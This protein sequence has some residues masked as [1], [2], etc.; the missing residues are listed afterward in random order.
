MNTLDLCRVLGRNLL[1]HLDRFQSNCFNALNY[2][3]R[4]L[5]YYS[6]FGHPSRTEDFTV[7]V[8]DVSPSSKLTIANS[9]F[10]SIS[11]LRNV[12]KT[13]QAKRMVDVP[14]GMRN[15]ISKI[16]GNV[17]IRNVRWTMNREKMSCFHKAAFF[18]SKQEQNNIRI[19][20][21][22]AKSKGWLRMQSNSG[23]EIW[24]EGKDI[25]EWRLKI[26]A[27]PSHRQGLDF[28]SHVPRFDARFEKKVYV[29]P[30]SGQIGN[31]K[32]GRHVPLKGGS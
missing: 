25:A 24:K 1:N 4:Q 27:M 28:G 10:K 30:F 16:S 7:G 17:F 20:R 31:G 3:D 11:S 22:W 21:G 19:L 23:P 8:I 12:N 13:I 6:T 5:N 2:C 15:T 29:N 14:F 32:I 26:K 18:L 9:L